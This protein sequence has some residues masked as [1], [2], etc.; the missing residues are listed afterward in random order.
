MRYNSEVEVKEVLGIESW[1]N[2]SKDTFLRFLATMPEIDREVA[3]KLI[4]QIPEI[5]TFARVALDDAAKAY[6]ATLTSNARSQE[7][8][9]QIHLER[10]AILKAELAKDLS[11]EEWMRVLGDI[12]EVHLS[13]VLKDTENKKFL[14]EQFDKRLGVVVSAIATLAAV[15]FAAAK[16]GHK[17]G[18]SAGR[19]FGS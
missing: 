6:D 7:M 12:R 5:T 11:P 15:L 4:G 13:A 10:L 1:R 18:V 17:P 2:L 3:L 16:S 14:A 8:V 19:V 9:H